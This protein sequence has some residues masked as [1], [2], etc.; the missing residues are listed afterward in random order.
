MPRSNETQKRLRIAILSWNL[1]EIKNRRKQLTWLRQIKYN[2]LLNHST[3]SYQLFCWRDSGLNL[4][5]WYPYP[6][7][8]PYPTSI[9]FQGARNE[10]LLFAKIWCVLNY[11]MR[12]KIIQ[13]E[14]FQQECYDTTVT[15]FTFFHRFKKKTNFKSITSCC[16]I[17]ILFQMNTPQF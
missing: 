6:C 7:F 3:L 10:Y 4:E 15:L 2:F 9:A 17:F 12:L 5:Q 13:S 16:P 8:I 14:R 11:R 1:F